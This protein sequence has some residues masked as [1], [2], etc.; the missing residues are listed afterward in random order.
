M[1]QCAYTGSDY[2]TPLY[3]AITVLEYFHRFLA[4]GVHARYYS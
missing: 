4:K 2:K 1:T 3:D